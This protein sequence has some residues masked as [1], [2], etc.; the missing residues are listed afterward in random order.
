M[1]ADGNA[2]S[3][4]SAEAFQGKSLL[5]PVQPAPGETALGFIARAVDANHLGSIRSFLALGGINFSIKGDYL[6]RL[7]RSLPELSELLGMP[8]HELKGLWG[9]RPLTDDGKRKLGGVYLRPHQICH[10]VRRIPRSKYPPKV[11]QATWMVEHLNFCPVTWTR[12]VDSCPV[13]QGKLTW[14]QAQNVH[15]CA[16][17][18]GALEFRGTRTIALKHRE[19]LGWVLQLFSDDE[20]QVTEAINRVPPFFEIDSATDVYELV[21]AFGQSA[22]G[23]HYEGINNKGS[24]TPEHLAFGVRMLLDYPKSIWDLYR[25]QGDQSQPAIFRTALRVARDHSQPAVTRNIERLMS[26]H[27][28]CYPKRTPRSSHDR[29]DIV[30][31]SKAADILSVSTSCIGELVANGHLKRAEFR[32]DKFT[33][34]ILRSSVVELRDRAQKWFDGSLFKRVFDLP[35]IAMEQLLA[36]GWLAEEPDPAIRILRGDQSLAGTSANHLFEL[37]KSLNEVQPNAGYISLDV[38]FT[39][40][41]GREKPWLPV[42]RGGLNGKL[43]GGLAL[44]KGPKSYKI[45]VHEAGARAL[46][47]GGPDTSTP[48]IF[49]HQYYGIYD[50]SWLTLCEVERYLNCTAQDVSWLRRRGHITKFTEEKSRY[51]RASARQAGLKFMSTREAAAR[52]AVSPKDI[53]MLLDAHPEVPSI[54]QGFHDREAL[55]IVLKAEAPKSSWWS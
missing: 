37:L 19:I 24:W 14:P 13:C 50:R 31:H 2:S 1:L 47:M 15:S 33:S 9:I 38:A 45:A 11:H 17:C 26:H 8:P 48:Y 55:E 49:D 22:Y 10:H 12:L 39:G 32:S 23:A 18:G 4:N 25:E 6:T 43:P 27:W 28:G 46:I 40:V 51:C 44:L 36:A 53:W 41:G 3:L 35:R 7:S 42:L 29:Y 34:L 5:F 30:C 20:E 21:L 52:L 54:G 16:R